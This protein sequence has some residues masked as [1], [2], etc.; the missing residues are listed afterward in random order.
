MQ[1]E[2]PETR[3]M[4]QNTNSPQA[5]TRAPHEKADGEY[6]VLDAST[7]ADKSAASSQRDHSARGAATR[8]NAFE[9]SSSAPGSL[10]KDALGSIFSSELVSTAPR[11]TNQPRDGPPAANDKQ[12]QLDDDFSDAGSIADSQDMYTNALQNELL[13]DF[14]SLNLREG[15]LE[16]LL[17]LRLQ[18]FAVRLGH[19]G[20]SQDHQNM[21]YVAHKYRK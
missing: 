14:K 7:N 2:A 19:Q 12:D 8:W 3:G 11:G 5:R 21:M 6:S 17:A 10:A 18:E 1:V 16:P 4:G 9:T 15:A 20:F 13:Q